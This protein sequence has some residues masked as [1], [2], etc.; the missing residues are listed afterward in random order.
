MESN[1]DS[2]S[3]CTQQI[4]L[5]LLFR[6]ISMYEEMEW[7]NNSKKSINQYTRF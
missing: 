4:I 1:R 2:L 5:I 7:V 3:V 6:Y